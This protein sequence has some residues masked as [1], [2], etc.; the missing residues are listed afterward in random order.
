MTGDPRDQKSLHYMGP[1]QYESQYMK[2]IKSVGAVLAPYDADGDIAAFGVGANLNPYGKQVSHCFNV[3]LDPNKEE[4]DG[5][6]GL[7]E[8]YKQCLNKVQLYGPTYFSEIL[9]NAAAKSMGVCDQKSQSYNILLIITDGVINDMQRSIDAVVD[10][11]RLP[12]SIIIVGVG[13]AD[14]SNMDILDV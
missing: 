12:L 11:T 10:A 14:F 6:E 9:G 5:I 8:A 13:N 4:V 1:P 3:T 2:V 7:V